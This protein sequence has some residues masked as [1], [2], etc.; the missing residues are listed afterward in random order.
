MDK[1]LVIVLFGI[2]ATFVILLVKRY[3]PEG[4]VV[5]SVVA[6]C[7]I[8][9]FVTA[10]LGSVISYIKSWLDKGALEGERFKSLTKIAVIC[11][12]GQWGIQLCRDAGESSIADK[13]ET[14]VKVMVLLACLPYLDILFSLASEIG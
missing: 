2:S 1:I 14:A 7:A 3:M 9:L 6:G 4:R 5:I 11:F 12:F 10:E 13:M 8:I